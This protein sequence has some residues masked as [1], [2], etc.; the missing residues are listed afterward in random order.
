MIFQFHKGDSILSRLIRLFS[1]GNYNHVSILTSKY[2]Y[3][4]HIKSGVTKTPIKKYDFSSVAEKIEVKSKRELSVI[5]WLDKQVGKKYDILGVLSF[6]SILT[7][8][9]KGYWFCSELAM[10]AYSRLKGYYGDIEDQKVSPQLFYDIIKIN[11]Y[12]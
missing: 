8:P 4:A 7:K 1:N 5:K 3:E 2:V 6:L 12:K 11:K 10:V 9:R